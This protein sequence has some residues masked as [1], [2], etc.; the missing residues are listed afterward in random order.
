MT[1]T[2]PSLFVHQFLEPSPNT[3]VFVNDKW[4][5]CFSSSRV[6]GTADQRGQLI[7]TCKSTR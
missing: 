7:P 5:R 3:I 1:A 4:S 6:K 2:K